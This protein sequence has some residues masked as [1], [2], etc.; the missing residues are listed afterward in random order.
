MEGDEMA[1][2]WVQEI[3]NE[4]CYQ[5]AMNPCAR[6]E[7]EVSELMLDYLKLLFENQMTTQEFRRKAKEQNEKTVSCLFGCPLRVVE[8]VGNY[9]IVAVTERK[10]SDG[11][12]QSSYQG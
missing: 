8:G 7:I 12:Y 6:L 5:R 9:R 10:V 11:S 3:H 2:E 1:R 4:M